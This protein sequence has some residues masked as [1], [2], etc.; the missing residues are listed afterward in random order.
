MQKQKPICSILT[1]LCSK[2]AALCCKIFFFSWVPLVNWFVMWN[3]PYSQ[4]FS[5]IQP[6]AEAKACMQHFE[7]F[8]QQICSIMLQI[9]VL[10]ISTPFR[11]ICC[12][13][14]LLIPNFHFNTINCRGY[15]LYTAF[16][17]L[18]TA[19]ILHY[20]ANFIFKR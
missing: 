9:L 7:N 17:Q 5:L 12:L 13:K 8:M 3:Y 15:N 20:A 4:I 2:Y 10:K 6:I 18:Y 14:L 19:S 16:G 1:T 11:L